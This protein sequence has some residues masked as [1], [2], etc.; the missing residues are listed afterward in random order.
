MFPLQHSQIPKEEKDPIK[1]ASMLI[2][3][4]HKLPMVL[5][6]SEVGFAA[7]PFIFWYIRLVHFNLFESI[8]RKINYRAIVSQL[9]IYVAE[10]I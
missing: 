8:N 1:Y 9:K 4:L 7:C 10:P 5:Y 3:S 6:V 2:P